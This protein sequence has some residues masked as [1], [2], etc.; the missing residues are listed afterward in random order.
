[1]PT[2]AFFELDADKKQS[3]I[4][5]AVQEFASLPYEKV[6]MFKI[7]QNAGVSRSGLYYY[8]KDK[9][10][11]YRYIT[12]QL[13]QPFV[14]LIQENPRL[15]PF[16][17]SRDFFIFFA[18]YKNTEREA[19]LRQTLYNVRS[20]EMQTLLSHMQPMRSENPLENLLSIIDRSSLKI[21][22][23]DECMLLHILVQT[24]SV[25]MLFAYLG[26]D[27]TYEQALE[28]LDQSFDLL[29]YGYMK[30]EISA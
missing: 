25:R 26:D 4:E 11:I 28:R 14:E 17:L 29:R 19:L 1:M 22:S 2:Q 18:R 30:Q 5:A 7:A 10:D 13:Y 6:S 16:A 27:L 9:E 23:A 15:D 3:L 12:E 21:T 24:V 8:F 20:M